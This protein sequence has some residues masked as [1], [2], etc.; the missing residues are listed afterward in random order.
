MNKVKKE[1][2]R[3]KETKNWFFGKV[4]NTE[5]PLDKL[6]KREKRP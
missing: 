6:S 3:I 2:K 5:K 1:A 4:S